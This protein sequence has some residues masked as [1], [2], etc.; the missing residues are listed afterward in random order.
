MIAKVLKIDSNG[1]T[2][3]LTWI[4]LNK[5]IGISDINSVG[6]FLLYFDNDVWRV[7]EFDEDNTYA[8][9]LNKWEQCHG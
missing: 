2:R 5:V 7:H 8:L 1:Y 3:K 9:I 6:E 4:D